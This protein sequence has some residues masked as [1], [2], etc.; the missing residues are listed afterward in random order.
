VLASQELGH[1]QDFFKNRFN[2]DPTKAREELKRLQDEIRAKKDE[3]NA[4]QVRV[5]I[6]REKQD[7]IEL[8]YHKITLKRYPPRQRTN[9]PNT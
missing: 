1:A 2:V 3:L 4:K 9:H 8:E 5:Q 7:A 6:I